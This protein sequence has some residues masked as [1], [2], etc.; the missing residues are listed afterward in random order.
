MT[1]GHND[2]GGNSSRTLMNYYDEEEEEYSRHVQ[3]A[4]SSRQVSGQLSNMQ[5]LVLQEK[6]G[7]A[8]TGSGSRLLSVDE[9]KF[10]F[11]ANHAGQHRHH[12]SNG[13]NGY[14]NQREKRV[15]Y[16]YVDGTERY[17]KGFYR[18]T[19]FD[20]QEE[21]EYVEEFR[22][23]R[24]SSTKKR[25]RQQREYEEHSVEEDEG[26]AVDLKTF[27]NKWW[28]VKFPRRSSKVGLF[29]GNK[30]HKTRITLNH[31]TFAVVFE[32]DAS[33][34]GLVTKV[35]VGDIKNIE[36]V[37]KKNV[38]IFTHNGRKY[39]IKCQT[40]KEATTWFSL[41]NQFVTSSQ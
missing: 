15:S 6:D 20:E 19:A 11:G 24:Q 35:R 40:D 2:H 4:S 36:V 17:N 31:Q 5:P 21:D 33:N 28:T 7:S 22:A 1:I 34:N 32:C 13:S 10:G 30:G 8:T 27:Y 38:S 18:D 26:A 23:Q 29:G 39:K 9:N 41:L 37:E 25:Y 3:S 14:Q 12:Q 16:D